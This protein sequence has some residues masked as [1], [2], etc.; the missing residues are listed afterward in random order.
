VA[1]YF[2]GQGLVTDLRTGLV[3]RPGGRIWESDALAASL[4]LPPEFQE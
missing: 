2:E 4:P 3:A 1:V